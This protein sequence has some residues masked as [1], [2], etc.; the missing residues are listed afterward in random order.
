MSWFFLSLI[1]FACEYEKYDAAF[2]VSGKGSKTVEKHL[3]QCFTK[4]TNRVVKCKYSFEKAVT[5]DT[6]RIEKFSHIT[7][8]IQVKYNDI[9]LN[10]ILIYN[11]RGFENLEDNEEVYALI[12][13]GFRDLLRRK[14]FKELAVKPLCLEQ[15]NAKNA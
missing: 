1:L 14:E 10:K 8:K 13:D 7:I 2:E 11:H 12:A 6:D 15:K 3:E 4:N 5:I 9:I